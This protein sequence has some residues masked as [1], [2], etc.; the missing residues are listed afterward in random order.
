MRYPVQVD[1][2]NIKAQIWDTAGQERYRAITS[3]VYRGA[4]GALLGGLHVLINFSWL[5]NH[6]IYLKPRRG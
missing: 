3:T 4:V 2:K 5:V 1:G 6:V